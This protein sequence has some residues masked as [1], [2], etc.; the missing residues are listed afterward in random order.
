MSGSVC[1][2][3]ELYAPTHLEEGD[4]IYF[5]SRTGHAA[6]STSE[7]DAEVLWLINENYDASTYDT[8]VKSPA[9]RGRAA[10]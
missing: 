6:V 2:H 7:E 10:G 5:D 9:T 3:S 4:S 8:D 1:L